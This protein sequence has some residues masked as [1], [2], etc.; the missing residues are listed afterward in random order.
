MEARKTRA[1]DPEEFSRVMTLLLMT[2]MDGA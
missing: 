1:D 2:I